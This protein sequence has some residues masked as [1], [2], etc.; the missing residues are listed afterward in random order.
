MPTNEEYRQIVNNIISMLDIAMN[1]TMITGNVEYTERAVDIA[2]MLHQEMKL[3][4]NESGDPLAHFCVKR[5]G[6][7]I[8]VTRDA[9]E[10][11]KKMLKSLAN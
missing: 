11:A 8:E 7:A 5:I 1:S 3:S 10:D 6:L 4:A 9:I 2:D